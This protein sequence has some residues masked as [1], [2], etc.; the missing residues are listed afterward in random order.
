MDVLKTEYYLLYYNTE[1]PESFLCDDLLNMFLE[2][3]FSDFKIKVEGKTFY[4][5]KNI[6]GTRSPGKV[7][8]KNLDERIRLFINCVTY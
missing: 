4:G 1:S 3:E 2:E 6:L 7:Y 8:K 5:H